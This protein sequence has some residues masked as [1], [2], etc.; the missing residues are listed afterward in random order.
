LTCHTFGATIRE[1]KKQ[2]SQ[3]KTSISF[4]TRK[5]PAHNM[6]HFPAELLHIIFTQLGQKQK[7][8][9]ALVC[10]HWWR[11]L[12]ERSLVCQVDVYNLDQFDKFMEMIKQCPH[13]A[14]QV[15]E[16]WIKNC[17]FENF[18]KRTLLN[19][20]PNLRQLK[21]ENDEFIS[22]DESLFFSEPIEMT[23][24]K[25]KI[26]VLHDSIHCELASQMLVS[27]L[28]GKLEKLELSFSHFRGISTQTVVDQ[29]NNAPVL[30]ELILEYAEIG[31][32]DLENLHNN[33]PHL[34]VFNLIKTCPIDSEMPTNIIPVTSITTFDI[35][36]T[37][38]ESAQSQVNFYQYMIKK[39]STVPH[40]QHEDHTDYFFWDVDPVPVYRNGI[41]DFYRIIKPK[42]KELTLYCVTDGVNVF[43]VLDDT[44]W[45][46]EE[47]FA[48][49]CESGT[50]YQY[51]IQSKQSKSIQ[52][53]KLSNTPVESSLQRMTA[54]TTLELEQ[55]EIILGQETN[56]T[57]CLNACPAT[58]KNLIVDYSFLKI[59]PPETS[60]TCIETLKIKCRECDGQLG[61][62]LS[63][64]FPKLIRLEVTT[65]K[66]STMN[67]VL[68]SP[69]LQEAS[70]SISN[71]TSY[72]LVFRVPSGISPQHHLIAKDNKQLV[73]YKDIQ[74]L[75]TLSVTYF[76][77]KN[78]DLSDGIKITST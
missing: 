35:D 59:Y 44:N 42:K 10:R 50:L 68:H 30:K 56:L 77:K 5:K 73:D 21:I 64:C 16:M 38:V 45:Q 74:H 34:Q 51:L 24:S 66:F 65:E 69:S 18:N 62:V 29:L 61:E 8:Q 15:E 3:N 27:N 32:T 6:D 13:R 75:P 37:G 78:L 12:D 49:E 7:T 55:N 54:L 46:L 1:N 48:C 25:S 40:I 22:S 11:I 23:H 28:C 39:Y 17:L 63:T 4:I 71:M 26:K 72:G 58:L 19:T 31:A 70:F 14:A 2:N 60:L 41:F 47:L 53:L 20:F 57:Q 33:V 43:E 9:C 36:I 52:K 67:V 76:T